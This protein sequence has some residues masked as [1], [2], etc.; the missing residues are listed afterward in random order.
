MIT[1]VIIFLRMQKFSLRKLRCK[2]TFFFKQSKKIL[3]KFFQ[4]KNRVTLHFKT[5]IK[6]NEKKDSGN[7]VRVRFNG[8]QRNT[9]SDNDIACN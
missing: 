1:C 2:N 6:R 8:R 9:R 7:F 5:N 3:K 4:I